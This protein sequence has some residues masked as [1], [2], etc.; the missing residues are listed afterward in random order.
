MSIVMALHINCNLQEH[1]KNPGYGVIIV[2]AYSSYLG[3]TIC[4]TNPLKVQG[5]VLPRKLLS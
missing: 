5:C 1:Q 3:G 2:F 4:Y